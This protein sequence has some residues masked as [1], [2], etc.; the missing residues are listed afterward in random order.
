M[1]MQTKINKLQGPILVLGASGFIGANLIHLIFA[2][3]KDVYGTTSRY[4]AWRLEN[5][6]NENIICTDLLVDYNL[7]KL[8]DTIKP[9]TIFSCVAYGAYSFQNDES[10]IYR[11]N[12]NFH[13]RLFEQLAQRNINCCVI[14]GS[15]SEYGDNSAA[16][17]ESASL[18]P[19]SHY[20]VSKAAISNLAYYFG[21]KNNFPCVNLRLYSVY[22]P[23]EDSARLIPTVIAHGLKNT[24]PEFVDPN[25]TRDMIFVEDAC[26]AFIDAAIHL[27]KEHWGESF[28]I[29][30]GQLTTIR[31]IADLAK[32]I[33]NLEGEPHF[34]MPNR[35]WDTPNWHANPEKTKNILGWQ[36]TTALKDGLLKTIAWYQT[37]KNP[38]HYQQYSKK[39]GL[40]VTHSISAIIACYKDAQAI[41]IMYERLTQ[42]F[43][44]LKVDYEIIFVNDG[45][46]D[47]SEAIIRDISA[48]DR[49]VIGITH[50][51]NFGSQAAFKSGMEIATKNACVLLDGDLQD[52]PELIEQFLEQWR[53]GYDV[54][55]GRRVKRKAP[56]YMRFFYKLFYRIFDKFSYINIPHDAGDFSLID[57]RVVNCLLQFPERDL[58]LRGIRAFAGFKQTGVDYIRPE[59]LFGVTTNNFLKNIGWA[60]KGIL[61]F[62]HTPLNILSFFGIALFG[63]TTL[64]A[65]V[66][67]ILK[68]LFPDLTPQG[69]TTTV[70]LIMFF[71]S[72][73]IFAISL[74]GEYIA[75][76]FEETKSRPHFIRNNIIRDGEIRKASEEI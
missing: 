71:G 52:P 48:R 21:K 35:N 49:H 73:N 26:A 50:S 46:P 63:V 12:L 69:I 11:T 70:L 32:G 41:P 13:V 1:D 58:F 45:S 15:S 33:F 23:L 53:H 76:I 16:P 75:K 43:Q 59:R 18:L 38:Q 2:Q 20:A 55:Y 57:K 62:S 17:A 42:T 64:L 31:E 27:E 10:L 65:C 68:L 22:G 36:A 40:N 66:Q 60:K 37:L 30:Q 56:L 7:I 51:R 4:P 39:F 34:T 47:T 74:I 19:N 3:R 54:V 24:Y 67:V 9:R 29:G 14:A 28:N 8:L 5:I 61:S 44:K 72:I 6:S 25:T